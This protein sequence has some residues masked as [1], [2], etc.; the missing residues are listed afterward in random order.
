MESEKETQ[1]FRNYEYHETKLKETIST[2]FRDFSVSGSVEALNE[3]LNDHLNNKE[4]DLK[5]E[6]VNELVYIVNSLSLFL[7]SLREK[8]LILELIENQKN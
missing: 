1:N 2:F 8:S 3:L 6:Q 7:T 5:K 4:L